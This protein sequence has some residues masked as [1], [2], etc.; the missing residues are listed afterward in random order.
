MKT[1]LQLLNEVAK[2]GFNRE[3]ALKSIDMALDEW[4]GYKAR[5]PIMKEYLPDSLYNNILE[6]FKEEL[7]WRG[8]LIVY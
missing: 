7:E 8:E 5:K 4:L 3:E 6:G 2:M 1:T